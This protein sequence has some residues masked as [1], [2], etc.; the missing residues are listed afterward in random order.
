MP[1]RIGRPPVDRV[2]Y[3]CLTCGK[4]FSGYAS[5]PR[6][7]CCR[8]CAG[9]ATASVYEAAR[10]SVVC[11]HCGKRFRVRP[12]LKNRAYCSFKCKQTY[13]ARSTAKQ[14]ADR[15]RFNGTKTKYIKFMGRHLHRV[16]AEQKIGRRLQ[17]GEVVHHVDGNSLNNDPDNLV[18]ITQSIHA[19]IHSTKNRQCTVPGC[20]RKH[21][22]RGMC[23]L[24]W[25]RWKK[26]MEKGVHDLRTP[27]PQG[28]A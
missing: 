28:G 14:R 26:A 17:N 21:V 24:H 6:K 10:I 13:V 22:A 9:K 23:N 3:V 8:A 1:K 2:M 16:M 27:F 15:M 4:Q 7:Y 25:K 12:G 5:G 18:V 19:S 20:T 11:K